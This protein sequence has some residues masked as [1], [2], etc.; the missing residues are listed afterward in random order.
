MTEGCDEN[1]KIR[2]RG[3]TSRNRE[4]QNNVYLLASGRNGTL[5]IG[6]TS[7][8]VQRVFQH[9]NEI[10]DG[11]SKK[12]GVKTLVYYEIHNDPGTV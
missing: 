7:D 10:V 12:Y 11:F 6:I 8:L 5:Y 9:K 4:K 3:I 2:N 1:G